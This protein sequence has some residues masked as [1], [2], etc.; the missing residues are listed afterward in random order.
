MKLLDILDKQDIKIGLKSK[1]KKDAIIELI[2]ILEKSGK[3]KNSKIAIKA[4]LKREKEVTT[5]IG[6]GIAIPHARVDFLNKIVASLGISKTGIDFK[7]IDS[8]KVY[9]IFLFFTPIDTK[10]DNA[11]LKLLAKIS[12]LFQNRVFRKALIEA[13]TADEIVNLIEKEDI[14]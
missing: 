4:I 8:Q 3:I 6:D 11:H 10:F 12:K 9:L 7:A 1:K 13:E 2:E 5:G 14:Y